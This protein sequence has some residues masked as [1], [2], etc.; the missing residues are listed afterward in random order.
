MIN[1]IKAL[2]IMPPPPAPGP[3]GPPGNPSLPIDTNI[4]MLVIVGLTYGIYKL[5]QIQKKTLKTY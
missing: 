4:I 3:P 1:F 5:I 2:I